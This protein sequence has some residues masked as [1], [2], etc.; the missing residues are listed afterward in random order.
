M[1]TTF[2]LSG[3]CLLRAGANVST[4]FTTGAGAS[5]ID[6]LINQAEC[7]INVA[8][9][10][11]WIDVYSGL[12]A[13]VK[14]ILEE[15]SAVSTAMAIVSYD[16]SGYTSRTEAETILDVLRDTYVRDVEILKDFKAQDFVTGA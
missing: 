1:A 5:K 6:S 16:M 13:D 10:K 8:T 4:Y 9:R 3:A 2:C 15:A 12:N 7:G 11:N 14:L